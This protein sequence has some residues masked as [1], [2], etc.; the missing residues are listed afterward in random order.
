MEETHRARRGPRAQDTMAC[1]D[2]LMNAFE[3][4]LPA[5]LSV[6]D[7]GGGTQQ[8]PVRLLAE[9]DEAGGE[10][11]WAQLEPEAVAL[12][13]PMLQS[14]QTVE[15]TFSTTDAKVYFDTAV[16][17]KNRNFWF[18]RTVLLRLPESV[19]VLEQ[20]KSAREWVPEEVPLPS[21]LFREDA[22]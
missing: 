12:V 20:R 8:L 2:V 1:C 15:L 21:L 7:P 5:V 17:K 3:N 6:R 14:G 19:T 16:L 11:I 18:N 4:R 10:G 22:P 9:C 13:A